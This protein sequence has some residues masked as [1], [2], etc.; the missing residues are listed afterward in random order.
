[1]DFIIYPLVYILFMPILTII[2]ELGHAIPALIFTIEEVSINIGN[3][4]LKNKQNSIDY[5]KISILKYSLSV[6]F[7]PSL[8]QILYNSKTVFGFPF[9]TTSTIFFT[10]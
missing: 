10:V 6:V 3:S 5:L 8:S 7:L 9:P 4:N 2:H 1:M